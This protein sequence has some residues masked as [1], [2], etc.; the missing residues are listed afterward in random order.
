[1]ERG[2]CKSRRA[3]S[4]GELLFLGSD[5]GE[6]ILSSVS[7]SGSRRAAEGGFLEYESP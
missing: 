5:S 7:V 4:V 2:Y 3:A 6:L 1:M